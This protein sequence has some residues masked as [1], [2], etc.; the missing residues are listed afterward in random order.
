VLAVKRETESICYLGGQFNCRIVEHQNPIGPGG[1][2][3]PDG[4]NFIHIGDVDHIAEARKGPSG[5]LASGPTDYPEYLAEILRC[6]E[7]LHKRHG[8]FVVKNREPWTLKICHLTILTGGYGAVRLPREASSRSERK[9][10]CGEVGPAR[11]GEAPR[12]A[13]VRLA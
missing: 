9:A 10:K 4:L 6:F 8:I 3:V 2:D 13:R 12:D 1:D 11:T 5:K 7:D